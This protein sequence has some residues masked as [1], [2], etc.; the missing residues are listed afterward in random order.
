MAVTPEQKN[1]HISISRHVPLSIK[2]CLTTTSCAVHEATFCLLR[3]GIPFFL[4]DSP[5]VIEVLVQSFEDLHDDSA[6]PTGFQWG[7]GLEKIQA[8]PF[9]VHQSLTADRSTVIHEDEIRSLLFM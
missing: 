3:Y 4:K 8:I 1:S 6:D 2:Y 9:E 5:Q 7:S